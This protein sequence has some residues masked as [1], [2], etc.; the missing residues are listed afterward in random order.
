MEWTIM[1]SD[2]TCGPRIRS[3]LGGRLHVPDHMI[4][5]SDPNSPRSWL[6]VPEVLIITHHGSLWSHSESSKLLI[7]YGPPQS[8]YFMISTHRVTQGRSTSPQSSTPQSLN[9]RPG[10]LRVPSHRCYF[11]F[12]FGNG[13]R[14][15]GRNIWKAPLW[16]KTYSIKNDGGARL[17]PKLPMSNSRNVMS[18]PGVQ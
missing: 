4:C 17:E 18:S 9:S 6:P 1:G 16:Y 7:R 15:T 5:L 2:Q 8:E 11:A 13:T 12:I 10:L 14:T 3:I